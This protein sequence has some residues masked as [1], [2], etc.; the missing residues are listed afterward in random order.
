[1]PHAGSLKPLSLAVTGFA[2]LLLFRAKWSVLRT[3]GACSLVG[4]MA[5]L[6]DLLV[7]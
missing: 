1:V 3:L 4:L 6:V 5:G 2:A 7:S